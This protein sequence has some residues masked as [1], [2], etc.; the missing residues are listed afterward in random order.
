VQQDLN[1][2]DVLRLLRFGDLEIVDIAV[3]EVL[4]DFQ[5]LAL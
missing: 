1:R 5:F 2:A 3:V 4:E